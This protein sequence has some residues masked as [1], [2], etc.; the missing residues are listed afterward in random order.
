MS[1]GSPKTVL[2]IVD[3]LG[4]SGKT[5][6]LVHLATHLDQTR[7]KPAVCTLTADH[8]PL[9]D[10]L[11]AGNVP[12]QVI[13]C[14]DGLA[15]SVVPKLARLMRSVNATIVHCYNPRPILYGGLA[16]RAIGVNAT[17]GFLSAFACHVPD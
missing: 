6:T 16:A 4:L 2:Y 13:G 5:R 17:I 3:G 12:V 8:T 7:F 15:V 11:S 9:I 14:R 1:A 10:L